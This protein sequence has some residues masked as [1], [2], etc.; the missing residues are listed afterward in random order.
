MSMGL[1]VQMVNGDHH[2]LSLEVA[3]GVKTGRAV[4][5]ERDTQS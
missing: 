4:L 5:L 3:Q 1:V 2:F